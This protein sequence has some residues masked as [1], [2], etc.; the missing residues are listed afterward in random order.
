MIVVVIEHRA[1]GW[2]PDPEG[3]DQ[4]RY[5]NGHEWSATSWRSPDGGMGRVTCSLHG[6]RKLWF[7]RLARLPVFFYPMACFNCS[8]PVTRG[9][10]TR[11]MRAPEMRPP[12]SFWSRPR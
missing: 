3:P 8:V 1:K 9:H 10:M 11:F 2:Y 6:W 7:Q 4:H 12:G 5:W